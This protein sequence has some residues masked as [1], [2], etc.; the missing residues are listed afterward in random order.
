VGGPITTGEP[1]LGRSGS[2]QASKQPLEQ[3]VERDVDV[4]VGQLGTVAPVMRVGLIP[5]DDYVTAAYE[6]HRHE[7][8]S[9]LSRTMR[10]DTEA[11]DLVQE[12]YLRLAREVRAGRYPDDVRAWLFRVGS[13]LAMSRFRR[14]SVAGRWL[15]RSGRQEHERPA[16]PSP[17]RHVIGRER[18]AEMERAL[19]RLSP[20]ERLA[21]LLASQGFSGREV[22]EA[23]GRT[24]AATRTM[25]CRARMRIRAELAEVGG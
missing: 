19:R 20:D 3:N 18:I 25:I 6:S 9:V 2:S 13:N 22:A 1:S 4:P 8:F 14:R 10:D 5:A 12:A 11:E 17:E 23:I 24:E 15:E 7:I 21:L 16:Q